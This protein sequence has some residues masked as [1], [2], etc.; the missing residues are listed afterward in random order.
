VV[1]TTNQPGL[2]HQTSLEVRRAPFF[3]P[4]RPR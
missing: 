2:K 3:H 4:L 1:K